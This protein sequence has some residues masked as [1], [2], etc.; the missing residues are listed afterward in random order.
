MGVKSA[1]SDAPV[2]PIVQ[3][4]YIHTYLGATN[5]GG[6]TTGNRDAGVV[7][8]N[9]EGEVELAGCCCCC[10]ADVDEGTAAA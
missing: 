4:T 9:T 2:L 7:L 10:C 3:Q 5:V 8:L 6:C 1:M